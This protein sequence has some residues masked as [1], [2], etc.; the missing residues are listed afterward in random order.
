[1]FFYANKIQKFNNIFGTVSSIVQCVNFYGFVKHLLVEP[2]QNE[3][4]IEKS[5]K[6]KSQVNT[7]IKN[8]QD[9]L[10]LLDVERK[11]VMGNQTSLSDDKAEKKKVSCEFIYVID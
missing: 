9:N 4:K 7:N 8:N 1:M 5:L 10:I 2:R 11:H 6:K 3:L